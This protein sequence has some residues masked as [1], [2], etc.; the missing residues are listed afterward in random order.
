MRESRL[1]GLRE[2]QASRL[3]AETDIVCDARLQGLRERQAS[4]LA[5]ETDIVCNARLQG[6]RERQASRLAAETDTVCDA[7]LQD[8]RERQASVQASLAGQQILARE[9]HRDSCILIGL[10][11]VSPSILPDPKLSVMFQIV[12]LMNIHVAVSHIAALYVWENSGKGRSS[13]VVL[14]CV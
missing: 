7:R 3:A 13:R 2:R 1:Q 11:P 5:A 9:R 8:N 4:R 14:N 6:L 12:I 10:Q